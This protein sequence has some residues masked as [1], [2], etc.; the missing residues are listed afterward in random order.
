MGKSSTPT[1][2]IEILQGKGSKVTMV[3]HK[4][5]QITDKVL[6]EY[7]MKYAKSYEAGGCNYRISQDCGYIPYPTMAEVINQRSGQ[8][9]ATWIAG[10]FQEW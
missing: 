10:K 6:E 9:K 4:K 8:I 5:G 2:R 3:W 7:I 1:H